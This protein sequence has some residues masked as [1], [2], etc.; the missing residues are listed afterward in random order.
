M[1]NADGQGGMEKEKEKRKI[2]RVFIRNR[3]R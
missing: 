3:E 1:Y 2:R